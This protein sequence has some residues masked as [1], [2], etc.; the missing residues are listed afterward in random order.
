M[1]ENIYIVYGADEFFVE[2]SADKKLESLSDYSIEIINGAVN[3]FNEL[4]KCLNNIIDSAITVDFFA[5]KKCVFLKNTNVFASGSP[6]MA[7]GAQEFIEEWLNKISN[8]P[9]DTILLVSA[10]K[11]DK[12]TKFFK[13]FVKLAQCDELP[14][15]K[16]DLYL[17]HMLKKIS[18]QNGIS[19]E[20][21]AADLLFVKLNKNPRMI[22]NEV[23]KLAG[24][25]NFSG[26]VTAEIVAKITP[27]LPSDNFFEPIEAFYS[28]DIN[29]AIRSFRSHF[30][31]N[32]EFRSLITMLLNRN[33]LLIQLA[34]LKDKHANFDAS[35]KSLFESLKIKYST[36]FNQISE[37][38]NFCVFSQ[39]QW[40]L[41]QLN[42]SFPLHKL[43]KIHRLIINAFDNMI[44]FHQ[45]TLNI[46]ENFIKMSHCKTV[47]ENFL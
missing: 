6:A 17:E 36:S 28:G 37:K 31:I 29:W 12:R 38:T 18:T 8:L 40:F 21:K 27:T 30:E 1:N 22:F 45:N 14:E 26:T 3:N 39:N 9:K 2:L 10:P 47:R 5:S 23:K 33:R 13:N 4:K 16:Y 46:M 15:A 20:K 24:F 34:A 25:L 41:S 44:K 11:V 19:F 43:I 7:E 42:T 32:K 35:S